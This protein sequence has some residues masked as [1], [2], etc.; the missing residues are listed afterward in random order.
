MLVGLFDHIENA[1]RPLHQLYDERLA[2][3]AAADAAG[4]YCIHLAEHH[5][6]PLCLIPGP[7]LFLAAL[8][9]TTSRIRIGTLVNLLTLTSPLGMLEEIAMLD[10]LS[11]GRLEVG[12]GRGVSPFELGYNKVAFEDSRDIFLDAYACLRAGLAARHEL[13]YQGSRY[14]YTSAP[15]VLKP[16]QVPH[17]A[18]WYASSNTT[19]S[20]WA[21]EQGLHFATL[22]NLAMAKQCIDA[23]K[24]ALAAR[25]TPEQPKAEFPGGT[26]IGLSRQIVVAETDVAATRIAKGPLDLHLKQKNWLREKHGQTDFTNRLRAPENATFEAAVEEGVAIVG[27]PATVIAEIERQSAAL[28]G[29][30]YLIAY[31]MFGDMAL[32]DARRSM[33]LFAREV[34]PRL[35]DL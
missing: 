21:G 9:R 22:G 24:A 2:F 4:F 19:G 34:M 25:G 30:N 12:V 32:A 35:K 8:A 20:R 6:S 17:P 14:A 28:G 1:N 15:I 26:V 18:I 31:M 23:Y 3:Y 11:H 10:Q 29:F 27:S 13:T 33:Q 7:G 5:C 16:S